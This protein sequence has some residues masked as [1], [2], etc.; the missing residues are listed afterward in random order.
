MEV[1]DVPLIGHRHRPL[2]RPDGVALH[3]V[4]AGPKHDQ[5]QSGAEPECGTKTRRS[6]WGFIHRV[7]LSFQLFTKTWRMARFQERLSAPVLVKATASRKASS[8]PC[9]LL[10]RN[11]S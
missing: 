2:I 6:Q 8:I 10:F 1:F 11:V 7:T 5:Q 9:S 3:G 4:A